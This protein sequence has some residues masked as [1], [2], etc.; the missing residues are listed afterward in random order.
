MTNTSPAVSAPPPNG[1]PAAATGP[2]A[3]VEASGQQFWL[4]PNR[5]YD[6]DRIHA[7][8]DDT[9]T[10]D[11]VLLVRDSSGTRLG[12]PHVPEAS[13]TLK[14]VAHRRGPKIIVYKMRPKKKTRR[15]NGHRQ[16][17]TRVVVES[18]TVGGQSLS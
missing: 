3:I 5:Y 15:K 4:Q 6:L 14:V 13:V 7:E 17:L 9:V 2:Y 10:L 11:Q 18:I 1:I 16:E 12:L 8:V